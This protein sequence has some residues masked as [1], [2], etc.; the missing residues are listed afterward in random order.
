MSTQQTVPTRRFG[1]AGPPV[2]AIGLGA[3]GM[4]WAYGVADQAAADAV[5]G[6]ALDL[7]CTHLD[8]SDA[9]GPHT[10]EELVG[11]AIAGRRDEVHLAT[12]AGL[13][14]RDAAAY[15]LGRDG[16]PAHLR[17]A[18]EGSLRRLGVDRVDVFYLHRVDPEVPVEETVGA[19]GELVAAGKAGGIGLSEVDV[20]T[21]DRAAAVHPVAAV[22]SE[23]SLFTRDALDG[24]VVAWCAAHGAAFVPYA[25]LGRGVLTGRLRSARE[26]PPGDFRATLPRFQEDALEANLALADRVRA[27]ADRLG[28]RPGQVAL[29]WVLAQG[30]DVVPIP[31]TK[32]VAYLEE[33]VAAALLVLDAAARAEL[34]GLP[35]PVGGRY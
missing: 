16:S 30:D 20:E 4:S 18:L 23:L 12:K 21:L 22:Q 5:I 34:D 8:T 24:G 19:M 14:V 6:R 33:N 7:G 35:A 29:A 2:G 3:M 1:A 9:Y 15:A 10:N 26:L 31:G 25:P 27:V 28:A 11:R 32:R 13:I 17:G